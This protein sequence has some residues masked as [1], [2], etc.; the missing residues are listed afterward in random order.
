M[1]S[2]VFRVIWVYTIFAHY[3][4]IPSLYLLYAFSWTITAAAE[5][6]YFLRCFRKLRLVPE[7]A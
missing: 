2:C 6:A 1:G 7:T 5:I 4:T 3:H